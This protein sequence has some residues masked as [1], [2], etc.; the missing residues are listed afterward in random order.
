MNLLRRKTCKRCNSHMLD[1]S[2]SL[3]FWILVCSEGRVSEPIAVAR[4]YSK[5]SYKRPKWCP[6]R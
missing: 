4:E 2:K 3:N 1:K 6:K 5:L